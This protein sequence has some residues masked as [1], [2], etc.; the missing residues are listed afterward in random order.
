MEQSQAGFTLI[1][2]IVVIIIVGVIFAGISAISFGVLGNS[3]LTVEADRVVETLRRAQSRSVNGLHD[4]VWSVHVTSSDIT[5]YKGDDYA[6]R[7]TLFDD[8]LELNSSVSSSL[9][10]VT[11]KFKTGATDDTGTITLTSPTSGTSAT[12]EINGAG[13]V[14]KQ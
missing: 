14:S 11:F 8:Q 6:T 7:D 5:L 13:L 1:E 9:N 4:D 3:R 10:D 12:I 2:V